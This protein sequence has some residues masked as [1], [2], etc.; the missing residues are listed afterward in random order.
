MKSN[1]AGWAG[2]RLFF[3]QDSM[4]LDQQY[5]LL[6]TK[7]EKIK[8]EQGLNNDSSSI[9]SNLA[10][11]FLQKQ[12]WTGL[13]QIELYLVSL[14]TEDQ[15]GME[16]KIKL[17]ES[18]EK[19]KPA[20][21]A[22]FDVEIQNCKGAPDN[23]ILLNNLNEKLQMVDDIEN[24]QKA[25]TA[26]TRMRTSFMFLIA[27][28]FFFA[29]DQMPSLAAFF[30]VEKG[31]RS[32]AIITAMASGWLG[33]CFSMLIGLRSKL[34]SSSLQELKVIHRMD[35]IFSRTIIGLISGLIV[36]YFFESKLVSSSLFPMLDDKSQTMDKV[37]NAL[38]IVWCF[39][40]GFSEKLVPDLL[41]QTEKN[42]AA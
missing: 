11:L 9:V 15:I 39:I 12:S 32:D 38:L 8:H 2:G 1:I 25:Y 23:R 35:Y 24:L 28:I 10:G 16:L 20:E 36:F 22:F 3:R 40:S 14:Y 5:K 33:T 31:T 41:A 6:D 7:F 34:T 13:S 18:R 17:L 26:K 27:I 42:L 37:S 19:L 21:V 29:V 4:I 30:S